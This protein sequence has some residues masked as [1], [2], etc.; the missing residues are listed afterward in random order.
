MR[1]LGS[2]VHSKKLF[3]EIMTRFPQTA[4]LGIVRHGGEPAAAGL[5]LGFRDTIEIPWASALRKYNPLSPN[6]LLYWSFLEYGCVERYRYFDFGRTTVGK[7]TYKFKEQWGAHP[8]ELYWCACNVYHRPITRAAR[9][10]KLS[11]QTLMSFAA[12]AWRLLPVFL[13]NLV[14]PRI[15]RFISL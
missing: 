6:M 3:N 7:G 14:G 15:R 2:P 12:S 5:I 4:R 8:K 13:T 10:P 1:D 11:Q 9:R